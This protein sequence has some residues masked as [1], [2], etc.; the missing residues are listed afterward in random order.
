LAAAGTRKLV[1]P[2]AGPQLFVF[3]TV[4]TGSVLVAKNTATPYELTVNTAWVATDR[5][6]LA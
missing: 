6:R 1:V 5:R 3:A 4:V 2:V